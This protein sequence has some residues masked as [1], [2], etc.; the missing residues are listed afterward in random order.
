MMAQ[1]AGVLVPLR[2]CFDE[3]G[4]MCDAT[5][6]TSNLLLRLPALVQLEVS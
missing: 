2:I 4:A 1:V 5:S 3:A 6:Q